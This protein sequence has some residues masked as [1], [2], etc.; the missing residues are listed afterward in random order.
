LIVLLESDKKIR[1]LKGPNRP[2]H[3]QEERAKMLS[4]I[5]YID[6]IICLPYMTTNQQYDQM[7]LKIHPSIIAVTKGDPSITHKKRQAEKI[8]AV[9]A[10]VVKYIPNK[11]TSAAVQVII[12]EK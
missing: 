4:A 5:A 1:E 6:A 3:T 8:D 2:L 11:S 12:N 9:V 10:E 7:V